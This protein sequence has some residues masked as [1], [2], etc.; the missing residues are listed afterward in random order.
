MT[1]ILTLEA[2]KLVKALNDVK[3]FASKKDFRYYLEGI[4]LT[5]IPCGDKQ[6]LKF[7]ATD[8]KILSINQEFLVDN[9]EFSLLNANI[10][11]DR[12]DISN[13]IKTLK[14]YKARLINLFYLEEKNKL[15]EYDPEIKA[16]PFL[17][18]VFDD[19]SNIKVKLIDAIYPSP[20]LTELNP[21]PRLTE[22]I[23]SK[24][25]FYAT[26][27]VKE[28]L[29][30]VNK[31]YNNLKEKKDIISYFRFKEK[32]DFIS[33]FTLKHNTAKH[34]TVIYFD[35]FNSQITTE[36]KFSHGNYFT[37]ETPYILHKEVHNKEFVVEHLLLPSGKFETYLYIIKQI[38]SHLKKGE[39]KIYLLGNKA[40]FLRSGEDG[41]FTNR[42]ITLGAI[43]EFKNNQKVT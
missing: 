19:G 16:T 15:L 23:E 37:E 24:G 10:I 31:Y 22:L 36:C 20:R 9:N 34:N 4:H 5:S 25:D 7:I 43:K 28:I 42:I 38:L 32:Q 8:G 29:S 35:I 21:N 2:N 1:L 6:R 17:M 26:F 11:I 18:F 14:P 41:E 39:V 13:I 27:D 3:G 33:S 40:T 12:K 30:I